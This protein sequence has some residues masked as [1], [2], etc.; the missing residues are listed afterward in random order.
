MTN[1]KLR[2]C[3]NVACVFHEHFLRDDAMMRVVSNPPVKTVPLLPPSVGQLQIT[4]A[5][6]VAFQRISTIAG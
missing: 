6:A 1:V 5:T 3:H 4:H 2:M